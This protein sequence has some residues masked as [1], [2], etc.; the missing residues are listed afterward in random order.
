MRHLLSLVL[1]IT[2]AACARPTPPA[3]SLRNTGYV[4]A[5]Q[6]VAGGFANN[7]LVLFDAETM[8]AQRK[9]SLPR[10]WAKSLAR[11]PEGN[12]WLGFSGNMRDSDRR[13]QI[14]SAQGDLLKT[15]E[16]CTDPEAG[17]SFAAGCAFIA[18]AENGLS[19]RVAVVNL[20]TREIHYRTL[21][22]WPFFW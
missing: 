17:I 3:V 4:L 1:L 15:L 13:V 22:D 21:F 16:P 9:I 19:G 5:G 2:L 7:A 18:C 12:L 14:Y 20:S 10:S 11:D 6:N 8:T